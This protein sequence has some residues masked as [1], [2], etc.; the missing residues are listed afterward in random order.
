MKVVVGG[1]L[2][3]W[4]REFPMPIW[5]QPPATHYNYCLSF[6]SSLSLQE[7]LLH[8]SRSLLWLQT[9]LSF[10]IQGRQFA[11]QTLLSDGCKKSWFL[12]CPECFLLSQWQW[13]LPSSLHIG[14]KIG[15]LRSSYLGILNLRYLSI[16]LL[17]FKLWLMVLHLR[18][19]AEMRNIKL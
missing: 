7:L 15:S 8:V 5:T 3:L 1:A 4:F 9:N 10:Q 13:W 11:L 6:P 16:G 2:R 17:L 19:S 12:L 14:Y 18:V